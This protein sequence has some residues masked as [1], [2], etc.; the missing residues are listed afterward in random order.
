MIYLQRNT[1]IVIPFSGTDINTVIRIPSAL[2]A[3]DILHDKFDQ[4]TLFSKFV[5]SCSFSHKSRTSVLSPSEVVNYPGSR[6][7][8]LKAAAYIMQ[9][10]TVSEYYK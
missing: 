4:M 8:V 9:I 7:I 6:E 10:A 1:E 3:E 2:E 5:S